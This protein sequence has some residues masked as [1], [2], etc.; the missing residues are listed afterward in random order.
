MLTPNASVPYL[1]GSD[2]G[3]RFDTSDDGFIVDGRWVTT[4]TPSSLQQMP[5]VKEA[6]YVSEPPIPT[7]PKA[8][9]WLPSRS[10]S[11]PDFKMLT[12][13]KFLERLDAVCDS[14]QP[15]DTATSYLIEVKGDEAP[16]S[17]RAFQLA[18]AEGAL[19]RLVEEAMWSGPIRHMAI[20][21]MAQRVIMLSDSMR[22]D[23]NNAPGGREL[24]V[25]LL[26][27]VKQ[28]CAANTGD[29]TISRHDKFSGR[30]VIL[31]G[32][33]SCTGEQLLKDCGE[34]YRDIDQ[35]CMLIAVSMGAEPAGS[36]Q[37]GKTIAAAVN[38][39]GEAEAKNG[40]PGT[41]GGAG[42]PELLIH[43]FGGAGFTA[44][45]KVLK[46]WMEQYHY[47]DEKRLTGRML[48]LDKILK[49]VVLDSAPGDSG[50]TVLGAFPMVQGDAALLSAMNSYA[51]DGSQPT[52][53]HKM[54]ATQRA[55]RDLTKKN[56]A[57]W[58]YYESLIAQDQGLPMQVHQYEPTVPLLF[59]YS[60]ADKIA[61]S[62]QI[63]RYLYE[64]ELRQAQRASDY[65]MPPVPVP[66]ILHLESS[67][68]VAHRSGPTEVDY[69]KS[70][71]DF[72]RF[73][74]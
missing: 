32:S 46:L 61:P 6:F 57:L 38:A 9:P 10:T 51:A 70:V 71:H 68:H 65:G 29:I 47:P 52:E 60:D 74:L 53:A 33:A 12:P 7:G 20:C 42:R 31:F 59:I 54:Q 28:M 36:A 73:S 4:G 17:P 41:A 44:W 15:L 55:M 27:S 25:S 66:R 49:G 69:W 43:L 14:F 21:V 19:S 56:G 58:E 26:S 30:I 24:M 35:N 63:E 18:N 23:P 40:P 13:E 39:W 67:G 11:N 5:P 34:R 8:L 22:S 50:T 2:L 45:A 3:N 64:C 16:Q 1:G 62:P 37:L 72:W 48:P